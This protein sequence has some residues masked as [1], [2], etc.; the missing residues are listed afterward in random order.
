MTSALRA[1]FPFQAT[2]WGVAIGY[3]AHLLGDALT[4][5]SVPFLLPINKTRFKVAAITTGQF[6]ERVIIGPL[7]G[8]CA[9]GLT[10]WVLV[11]HHVIP[12]TWV[13]TVA[14]WMP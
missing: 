1:S 14:P 11:R 3:L 8:L 4:I 9:V 13:A 7:L 5:Q 6:T 10:I 2:V 12:G